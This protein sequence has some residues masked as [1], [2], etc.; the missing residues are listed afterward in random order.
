MKLQCISLIIIV[1]PSVYSPWVVAYTNVSICVVFSFAATQWTEIK[2][3]FYGTRITLPGEGY[4]YFNNPSFETFPIQAIYYA[5]TYD[6]RSRQ[7]NS[8]FPL[9]FQYRSDQGPIPKPS[10]CSRCWRGPNCDVQVIHQCDDCNPCP[11]FDDQCTPSGDENVARTC[12]SVD[13]NTGNPF[14]LMYMQNR[15]DNTAKRE[16]VWL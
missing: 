10:F 6:Q 2:D 3:E 12:T 9:G 5:V 16:L 11:N 7:P 4:Y 1:K 14:T 13:D 15:P 8:A